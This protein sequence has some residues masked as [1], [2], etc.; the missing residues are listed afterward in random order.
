MRSRTR[1]VLAAAIAMLGLVCA[2][3][4]FGADEAAAWAA[5]Q[6]QSGPA[7]LDQLVD[8]CGSGGCPGQSGAVTLDQ[9]IAGCSVIIA[10]PTQTKLRRVLAAYQRGAAHALQGQPSMAI[11]DFSLAISIAPGFAEAYAARAA[12]HDAMNDWTRAISDDSHAIHLRPDLVRAYIGRANA[13]YQAGDLDRAISDATQALTL[14]P[15]N[16]VALN[17]RCWIRAASG[18]DLSAALADCN[19]AVT[20]TSGAAEML[21][22]RGLVELKLKDDRAA[23]ADYDASL[24]ANASVRDLRA[25]SLYGRGLARI[26]LG[27]HGGGQADLAAAEALAPDVGRTYAKLGL[28]P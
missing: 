10:S 15:N 13:Y 22:S 18:R 14:K 28:T 1:S 2:G 5:C 3:A 23:V 8:S 16:P 20:L 26:A 9:V 19:A 25:S 27:D 6:A 12:A 4:A 17:E 21:D 11:A 7:N 24:K